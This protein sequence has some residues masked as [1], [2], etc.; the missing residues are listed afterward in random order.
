MKI[1]F[2]QDFRGRETHEVFYQ[3]GDVA[4]IE[5]VDLIKR[6]ICEPVKE[7]PKSEKR[8]TVPPTKKDKK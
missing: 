1:K 5:P 6:G 7:A 3:A 2:L 8:A 4:D